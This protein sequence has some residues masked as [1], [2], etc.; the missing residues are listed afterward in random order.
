MR[1]P[2]KGE[3]LPTSW[4]S[5]PGSL[6]EAMQNQDTPAPHMGAS[7]RQVSAPATEALSPNEEGPLYVH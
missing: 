3:R 5:S 7:G 2:G 1:A 6:E 4:G